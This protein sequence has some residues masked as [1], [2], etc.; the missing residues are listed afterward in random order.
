MSLWC[1]GENYFWKHTHAHTW[2]FILLTIVGSFNFSFRQYWGFE[3]RVSQLLSQVLYH[4]SHT[5]SP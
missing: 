2:Q 1:L 3:L 4:W 5:T